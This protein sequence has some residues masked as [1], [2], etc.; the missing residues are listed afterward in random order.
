MPVQRQQFAYD[1]AQWHQLVDVY[2]D[3]LFDA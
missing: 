3:M 1:V 2:M